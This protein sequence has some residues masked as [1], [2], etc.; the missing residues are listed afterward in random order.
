MV[1]EITKKLNLDD[2]IPI[3]RLALFDEE[4]SGA[5]GVKF[6]EVE[7]A[8]AVNSHDLETFFDDFLGR[9]FVITFV[10]GEPVP[11]L[12]TVHCQ[13]RQR[14][15]DL[16]WELNQTSPSGAKKRSIVIHN[17][18]DLIRLRR[19]V[20]LKHLVE[21]NAGSTALT[22]EHFKV[23]QYI[24]IPDLDPNQV[25]IIDEDVAKYFFQTEH[26]Y[27]ATLQAINDGLDALE[28]ALSHP[29]IQPLITD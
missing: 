23:G 4:Q 8:Q 6:L 21:L 19:A 20:A 13:N 17:E 24:M 26:Y 3:P 22:L 10:E 16:T 28:N 1:Y 18:S 15:R 14:W 12:R 5:M 27:S 7:L 25:H 9:A 2:P 11:Q 29:E